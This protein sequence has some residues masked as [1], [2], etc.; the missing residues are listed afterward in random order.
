MIAIVTSMIL[1]LHSI[2]S[3]WL[4]C[5]KDPIVLNYGSESMSIGKIPFP[6][7]TICPYNRFAAKVFNYTA[8]YRSILKLDGKHSPNPTDEE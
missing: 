3:V 4:K 8:V 6:A 5:Q 1:C 2:Q 7:V